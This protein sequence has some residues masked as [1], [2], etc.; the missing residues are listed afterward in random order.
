[1][2]ISIVPSL[3]PSSFTINNITN[4][5]VL[6]SWGEIPFRSIH[7]ILQSYHIYGCGTLRNT[8]QHCFGEHDQGY[9]HSFELFPG[10]EYCFHVAGCTRVDC[11]VFDTLCNETLEMGK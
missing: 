7:G 9:N 2:F 5:T 1:M 11:G 6:L 10:T 3:P 4:D 8:S